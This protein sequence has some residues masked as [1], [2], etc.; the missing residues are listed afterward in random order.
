[1]ACDG[2]EGDERCSSHSDARRRSK[3]RGATCG[4]AEGRQGRTSVDALV[5]VALRLA[6]AHQHYAYRAPSV[7]AGFPAILASLGGVDAQRTAQPGSALR[8][9]CEGEAC[10]ARG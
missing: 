1:V 10:R 9:W 8:R 6:V 5:D 3:A 7:L 4:E 2:S